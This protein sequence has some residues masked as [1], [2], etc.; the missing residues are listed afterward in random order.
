MSNSEGMKQAEKTRNRRKAGQGEMKE[1]VL[2]RL[3]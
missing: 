1:V 3:S 2:A